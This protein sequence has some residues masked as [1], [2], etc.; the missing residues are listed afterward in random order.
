MCSYIIQM[1]MDT[2]DLTCCYYFVRSSS[3]ENICRHILAIIVLQL[4]AQHP[5]ICTL[6]ANKYAYSGATS[7]MTQL[8][9]LVPELLELVPYTRIVI[10]GIDECSEENQKSVLKELQMACKAKNSVKVLFSSRKE[11]QI[12]QRLSTQP[13]ILLDKC[14]EVDLDIQDF[15]EYSMAKLRTSDQNLQSKIKQILI[16]KANGDYLQP[17][18]IDSILILNKGCFCGL[19]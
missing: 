14:Q 1:L 6:I 11:I 16:K 7:G 15:I 12:Y 9:V 4:I 2:P 3:Q 18:C 5:D 10:D 19:D 8:R 13:K 17:S